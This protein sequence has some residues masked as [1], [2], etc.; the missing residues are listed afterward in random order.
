MK[1][2]ALAACTAA[3]C[4]AQP[5]LEVCLE[6]CAR[7]RLGAKSRDAI[8]QTL[9]VA[10]A[11]LGRRIETGC[12]ADAVRAVF[13]DRHES[14]ADVMGAVQWKAGVFLPS[15]D[16]YAGAIVDE[17]GASSSRRLGQAVGLVIAHELRHFLL[18]TAS[19]PGDG[20]LSTERVDLRQ[21]GK[22]LRELSK[23]N[24]ARSGIS[25]PPRAVIELV[26]K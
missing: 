26:R 9:D 18:R 4:S 16:V 3:L 8:V 20:P 13:S 17:L 1:F 2:A 10:G 15:I 12:S 24:L 14:Y 19:H 22:L 5:P 7:S 6:A 11:H 21:L 25:N 23:S